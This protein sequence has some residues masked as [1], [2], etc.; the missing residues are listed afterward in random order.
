MGYR[1]DVRDSW[2]LSWRASS[3]LTQ[4]YVRVA[5]GDSHMGGRFGRILCGSARFLTTLGGSLGLTVGFSR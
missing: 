5:W 2:G 3:D 1:W 4:V